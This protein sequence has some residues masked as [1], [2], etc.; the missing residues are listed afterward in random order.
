TALYVLCV[1]AVKYHFA[2]ADDVSQRRD[3]DVGAT[4]HDRGIL[5]HGLRVAL[6]VAGHRHAGRA[7]DQ[8]VLRLDCQADGRRD[9]GLGYQHVLVDERAAEI[10]CDRA[11]LDPAGRTV[12]EGRLR[13]HVEDLP[14]LDGGGHHRGVFGQAADDSDRVRGAGLEIAGNPADQPAAPDGHED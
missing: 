3:A 9:L 6:E 11:W 4:Q 7:L 1:F 5:A 13:W 10:E 12:G 14:G 2:L 8:L